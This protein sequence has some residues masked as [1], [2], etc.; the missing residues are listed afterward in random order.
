MEYR[1]KK[2]KKE[3]IHAGKKIECIFYFYDLFIKYEDLSK[4]F[5]FSK[6]TLDEKLSVIYNG[7]LKEDETHYTFND[8]ENNCEEYYSL[9]VVYS[10]IFMTPNN[11]EARKF[12]EWANRKLKSYLIKLDYS[13]NKNVLTSF[14]E[15]IDFTIPKVSKEPKVGISTDTLC[16]NIKVKKLK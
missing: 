3:Y 4:L 7:I 1:F 2:N 8:W 16:E 12:Y 9:D 6:T 11:I 5:S 10:L 13:K 15:D 14:S